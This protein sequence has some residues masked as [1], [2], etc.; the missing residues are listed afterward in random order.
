MRLILVIYLSLTFLDTNKLYDIGENSVL[1]H[2][3][4]VNPVNN[5]GYN[6]YINFGQNTTNNFNNQ[7]PQQIINTPNNLHNGYNVTNSYQPNSL[8][9]PNTNFSKFQPMNNGGFLDNNPIPSPNNNSN[10]PSNPY[11][12][13]NNNIDS[14]NYNY[15]YNTGNLNNNPISSINNQPSI[16]NNNNFNTRTPF[17]GDRLRM[18]ATNIIG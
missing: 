1:Q 9:N 18:A 11:N 2:N 14:A 7:I 15:Q 3:P 8:I 17:T 10:I 4:I 5:Y 12:V 13:V 6:R 16:N